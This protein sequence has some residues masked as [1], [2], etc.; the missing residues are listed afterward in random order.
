MTSTSI[1]VSFNW[2]GMIRYGD[3][4]V[5]SDARQQ[6]SS[7]PQIVTNLDAGRRTNLKLPLAS[8]YLSVGSCNSNACIQ[9]CLVMLLHDGATECIMNPTRTVVLPLRFQI[10]SDR[11]TNWPKDITS[12]VLKEYVLLLNT[13]PWIISLRLFQNFISIVSKISV[14][15]LLSRE[16]IVSPFEGLAEN[17]DVIAT[18]EWISIHFYRGEQYL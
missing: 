11:P 15:W 9:T 1:P 2:L 5:F 7:H 12:I 13:E 17:Q 4:F 16:G 6:V 3:S 8:K 10:T 14:C 18:P